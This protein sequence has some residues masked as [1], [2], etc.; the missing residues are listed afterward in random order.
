[1]AFEE[2]GGVFAMAWRGQ[3]PLACGAFRPF[4]GKAE[5]KRMFVRPECRGQGLSRRILMFLEQEAA[6][7]GF[8]EA[9]LETGTAQPEAIGLYRSAGW[10]PAEPFGPYIGDPLSVFFRKRLR[11]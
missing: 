10:Q 1:M 9:V 5:I 4:A 11:A 7:R 3:E 2:G 6:L 8:D